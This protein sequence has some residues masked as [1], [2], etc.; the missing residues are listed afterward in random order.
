[1]HFGKPTLI[2]GLTLAEQAYG[3][4]VRRYLGLALDLFQKNRGRAGACIE[5]L[6]VEN[7]TTLRKGLRVLR[8]L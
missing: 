8:A 3:A 4:A 2:E 5:S 7:T 1:V 6:A